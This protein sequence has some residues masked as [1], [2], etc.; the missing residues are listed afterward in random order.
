V[1]VI[2]IAGGAG[3]RLWPLSTPDYPKHLLRINADDLS[4]LQHTYERAKRLTDKIYVVSEA[5]HSEHVRNQLPDLPEQ[6][7]IVEPARRGTAN[8]IIAALDHIAK[9]EEPGEPVAAMHADHYIRDVAGFVHSFGVANDLAI[10]EKRIVLVGVEPDQP[11]TGFGYIEKAAVL[12][13]EEFAF[14]VK[15]FKEKPD[16]ATAQK[17]FQSGNYLWNCGFFVGCLDTFIDSMERY[18]PDLFSNYQ[19]L[20]AASPDSYRETYLSFESI[21]IDYALIEKVPDLLVVPALFDW[22]D[23]GSFADLSKVTA[24]EQEGNQLLGDKIEIDEVTNSY[25]QNYEDKPIAIIGMDNLVVVNTP[26]GLLITRKDLSQKVGDVSKR[27][28]T[29]D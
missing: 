27:F 26:Q 6:A 29:K 4:L 10:S 5:S 7:I 28:H 14:N 19:K 23:L 20:A 12:N 2:I 21:A 17:Y 18:A 25:V 3:S 16:F 8:C 1:I 13:E 9:H 15:S 22:I 11:A 24:V